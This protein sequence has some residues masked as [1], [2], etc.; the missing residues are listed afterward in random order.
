MKVRS[1]LVPLLCA[2]FLM[3]LVSLLW[4]GGSRAQRGV[5]R[6]AH[7][8]SLY[9]SI[10]GDATLP[11][12]IEKGEELAAD[13]ESD[14]YVVLLLLAPPPQMDGEPSSLDE[15]LAGRVRGVMVSM[16]RALRDDVGVPV[17]LALV[18][19][20]SERR[21]GAWSVKTLTMVGD[22]FTPP[23]QEE[24]HDC[25]KRLLGTDCGYD[26]EKWR[27]IILSGS[28]RPAGA[29]L[30]PAEAGPASDQQSVPARQR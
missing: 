26:K 18:E 4:L 27:E 21:R 15:L 22:G 12:A 28:K 14:P 2:I 16:I 9:D 20:L 3:L 7:C 30:R 10:M 24:A 13:R 25:L 19:K 23:V 29:A 8:L 6:D 11:E 5:T 1:Y 17:K